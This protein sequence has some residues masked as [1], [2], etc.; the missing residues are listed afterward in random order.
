MLTIEHNIVIYS[1]VNTFL[2]VMQPNYQPM[3]NQA[4]QNEMAS[5]AAQYTK[6]P[7]NPAF[8]PP[9]MSAFQRPPQSNQPPQTN[10]A[11][12]RP[13]ADLSQ[14]ISNLSLNQP[15]STASPNFYQQQ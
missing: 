6:P 7:M 4:S 9:P 12:V 1:K 15:A 2:F 14:Q 10:P 13:P 5:V 8:M 11:L 3:P